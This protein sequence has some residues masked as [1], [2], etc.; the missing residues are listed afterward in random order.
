MVIPIGMDKDL[1]EAIEEGISQVHLT[2]DKL[3]EIL[4]SGLQ[5]VTKGSQEWNY[6]NGL[7]LY[8]GLVYVLNKETLK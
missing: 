6:E 5:Q 1:K 2:R 4:L 8:K 7:M 3:K